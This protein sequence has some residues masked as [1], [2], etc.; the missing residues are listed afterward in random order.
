MKHVENSGAVVYQGDRSF[1]MASKSEELLP[2]DDIEE[3]LAVI[4]SDILAEPN[5]LETEFTATVSKIQ[6]INSESCFL[7]QNCRKTY[8]IKR[9]LNR[10]QSAE[11]GDYTKTY[12]ERLPLDTF[13]QFVTISKVKLANDQWF[14]SFVG[15]FSACLIDKECVKNVHK[16][17][18]NIV[19]SFKG[20]AEKFYPAFYKCISDA[21][22]PFGGSLNKH[23]SLLLGF[24]LANHVLGYLSGG[25]I[26]KDLVVQF[27]YRSHRQRKIN[28]VLFSRICVFYIFL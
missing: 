25:S 28:C 26:Q 5:D 13:D 17:R 18:S 27:K 24:E 11:H 7:C 12:E 20:D 1:K 4:D 21:E 23:A 16:L 2:G 22:N 3:I 9:G 10:H 6:H 14:E 15:E 19:L 8:K